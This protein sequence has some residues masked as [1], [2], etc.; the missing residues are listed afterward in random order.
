MGGGAS[1]GIAETLN[2]ASDDEVKAVLKDLSPDQAQKLQA[3]LKKVDAGGTTV[4][5]YC[6]E[7]SVTVQG[8]PSMQ[9]MCHCIDCRRWGGAFCQAA[10]LYPSDKVSYTGNGIGK[11]KKDDGSL[12]RR[13]SCGKCGGV[14]LDDMTAGMN[15][16][17]VPAGLFDTPF[18]PGMQIKYADRVISIKDGLT[19]FKDFPKDMGGSDEKIDEGA[20]VEDK[21]QDETVQC[22]CGDCKIKVEGDP[23]MQVMCHCS[24]CRK[25]GGGICQAARLYPADKVSLTAG[26][27]FSKTM[28]D[29]KPTRRLSCKK[30][31]GAVYDDMADAMKMIMVPAGHFNAPFKPAMHVMYKEAV[32]KWTDDL[33][34][35]K[36][37]P[38]DMGGSDEKI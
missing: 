6:G 23:A 19:K 27:V 7:S 20:D 18:T 28:K 37:F 24:D 32:Y 38:K 17:M 16:K 34:K 25:W 35:Y 2:K 21:P 15:M 14:L 31:G 29:D 26:E 3:A 36:D 30:C 5:C 13:I 9:V 8:D 22:Y 11:N 33:P 4:K 1:A 10:K 12:E